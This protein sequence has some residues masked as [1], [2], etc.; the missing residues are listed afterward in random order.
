MR[1]SMLVYI[2]KM[3][4][5]LLEAA[6]Y[7]RTAPKDDLRTSV[8]ENGRQMLAQIRGVLGQGDLR[9]E[10]PLVRLAEIETLWGHENP[11]VEERL[12]KFIQSLPEE[13]N[14][15]VRA[16]FF[17]ELGEKWDAMESVYEYM[18]D[19]PRFDP[20]VVRTPVGRVV[21][22]KGKRK[23]EIIYKDFLTPMGI[24]S[25]GY[26]QYDIE[27]DC[28]E[29]AFTSQ[30]YE[31]CTLEQFWPETIA[32]HT[33]L[34]YLP[35][36]LPNAVLEESIEPLARLPIYHFAWKVV[37]PTEKQYKFYCR[38]AANRGANAIV[39]GAPK[40]DAFVAIRQNSVSCPKKWAKLDGKTIFL[41]NS[42]YDISISSLRFFDE[43]ME[44]FKN[45]QECGMIWRPHPMMDTVTK[46][47]YPKRYAEYQRY[48]RQAEAAQNVVIDSE[49][50]CAVAFSMSDAMISD[51]SSLLPQYLILD[52]PALWIKGKSDITTGKEFV[53]HKWM[54][55]AYQIDEIFDFMIQIRD[56]EDRNAAQRKVILQRDLPL[57]DGHCGERVCETVWQELHQEDFIR[58]QQRSN[59]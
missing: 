13:V 45:H 42:W 9:S 26:D 39:T 25:L 46:L 17:A 23:Q 29:L 49:P 14:Y 31:S 32:K 30:P 6:Q 19:D 57:A 4:R 58:N 27:A 36:F 12:E 41:W 2:T 11:Q 22:Q 1:Y 52:K 35:Y 55:Q 38:Y 48:L 51:G 20:V 5:T 18:R 37:C 47:Y 10:G 15:Q 8:L 50:S 21:E 3:G 44:W 24:P 16:V 43:L 33:R 28:P 56:G 7:L 34:V 54:E 53:D 40:S 59:T